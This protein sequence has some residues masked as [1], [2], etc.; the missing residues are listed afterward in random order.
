[1]ILDLSFKVFLEFS[2]MTLLF[3]NAGWL[4]YSHLMLMPFTSHSKF[5]TIFSQQTEKSRIRQHSLLQCHISTW[6]FHSFCQIQMSLTIHVH[7]EDSNIYLFGFFQN[8]FNFFKSKAFSTFGNY[9]RNP[10]TW[11][12]VKYRCCW[13]FK[14][15]KRR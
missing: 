4:L 12:S 5:Q 3:A 15:K 11:L 13:G 7:G 6:S 9:L 1:M 14:R 10:L 2:R 8:C